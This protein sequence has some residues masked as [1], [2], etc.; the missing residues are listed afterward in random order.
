MR[1]L[2]TGLP[3]AL[4]LL[5]LGGG[6]AAAGGGIL[7][8][9]GGGSICAGYAEGDRLVMRDNCFEGTAHLA[10]GGTLE[11]V[12]DGALPHTFSAVDGGFDTGVMQ[13]GETLEVSLPRSGSFVVYCTLHGTPEGGGMAG[14]LTLDA[15]TTVAAV[16]EPAAADTSRSTGVGPWALAGWA[17]ALLALV[18]AGYERRRSRSEEPVSV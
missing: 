18:V 4:L 2:L 5:V 8:G 7:A 11:V 3:L 15:P 10:T 12:N 9:G 6:A 1:R 14:L 13:P 16:A 17:V